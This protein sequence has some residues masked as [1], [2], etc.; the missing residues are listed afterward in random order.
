MNYGKNALDKK[1]KNASSKTRKYTSMIFFGFF[2]TMLLLAVVCAATGISAG[3]GMMKGIIDSALEINIETI[4]PQ[5]F[6]TTVYDSAG[7]LTDTLVTAGSNRDPVTYEELP[8]DLIDAFVAIE[9][10]RFW[11]HNGLDLRSILR[12]AKGIL[13]GDSSAGGGSTITQQ[14]IKNNV[15]SGGAEKSFGEKLERKFQE[16]YLAVQLSK[17]MDKELV[18]TN[19]LNTINLGNNTLGVKV[20]A[21]RYF[22]KDVS[23]LTL[24][25]CAVIAGITQS[26]TRL[27][28]IS[29]RERNAEKREVILQYM[30]DQGY[31]TKEEQ[32][33]ALA[34]NVYDRI[35]N[36]DSTSKEAST[37]YSYFTDELTSQVKDALMEELGYSD[38]QAH[39]LLYSGGLQIITTQDPV[40]QAIVDEEVNNPDNYNIVRYSM[41]YRLSI[42]HP[43][44]TAEHFSQGHLKNWHRD[45]L[46]DTSFDALYD[47]EEEART[48]AENYKNYMV[49]EGDTVIGESITITLQ[50]QVSFVLMDQATGQVKAISGGRGPKTANLTLNRA[51]NVPRQ[52]GSAFKVISSFAPALDTCGV[53]LGTVYYDAP[54]TIGTKTF[55][56]WYSGGYQGYS[57]IRDGIIYSMNIVAV[58]CLMETVSPQLGVEYAKNFGIT[59]LTSTDVNPATALGGLTE[60]VTN[61]ELTAAYAA[62]ANGGMY[63]EPIFF[64]KILD[65]DGKVLI[66]NEPSTHRVLKDSTAFLLT[67]AMKDSMIGNRKFARPG[68]GPSATSTRAK[69]AD[70][71]CAGKSG[72]TTGNN[73]IWFVGF[74]PYYSAGIWAGYDLNQKLDKNTEGTSF[75]KDI[76]K[77][78]M[79]RVHE[80]L[81]D[82]GFA[83]PDS[84]ETASICRKSGKLAISGVCDGD[85][86]GN[87]IYTEYFA[88]GTVPTEVC[89][90]HVAATVCEESGQMPTDFCIN[91]V[92]RVFVSIPAGETGETDDS[93]FTLP[94]ICPIHTAESTILPPESEG[95]VS[96]TIPYGPGYVPSGPGTGGDNSPSY[97]TAP[98]VPTVPNVPVGPQG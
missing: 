52:P 90:V 21:R 76:W 4:V 6:A 47:S 72:T 12:A 53:T 62:I 74:T 96:P 9:D 54:Y 28:P 51:T 2:K 32:E 88:K 75:H 66:N 98:A 67:D 87:A 36:V 64:T 61:L 1:L 57:S 10:A 30:Y 80:G 73:D 23:D 16:Q 39:N 84:V 26:P 43:D 56:N 42:A 45:V 97:P 25:E 68:A 48:D 7:N 5:G 46:G 60:G 78:I 93:Y 14:L 44:G 82:P 95:E 77:K 13:T 41:E 86:R 3:F 81:P 11:T 94:G 89:N 33:E 8:Q 29:G 91:R 20:A 79:T 22:D 50:P 15:F 58:R 19:Y 17:T 18:L 70:M 40:L 34:D 31:I 92:P 69:L 49:K 83:V 63:T 37:P 65:R 59:T 85:P 55:R 38:T 27:N 71:S 24:S 35:Q